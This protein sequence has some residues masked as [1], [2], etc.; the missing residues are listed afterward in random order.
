MLVMEGGRVTQCGHPRVVLP[1]V[2]KQLETA[3]LSV[4]EKEE[5]GAADDKTDTTA[6]QLQVN[7]CTLQQLPCKCR[8]SLEV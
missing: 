7:I 3:K 6:S 5:G 1:L 2:E 4:E 8:R